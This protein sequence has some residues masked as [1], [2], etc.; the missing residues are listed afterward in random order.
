MKDTIFISHATPEDNEFTIWLASK[1]EL[2]GYK[3]WIDK[4]GLLGGEK[5]WEEI[6]NAIRNHTIKFLLVYSNNIFQKDENGNPI[7]GKLKDGVSKEYSFAENIGKKEKLKDFI[8]PLNIDSADY[9]LFIGLDRSNQI[10]FHDN[11]AQGLIQ[12]EKKL[13]KDEIVKIESNEDSNFGNWYQNEFLQYERITSKNEL[14]YTNWW[15]IQKLPDSFYMY[16]FDKKEQASVIRKQK[17]SFPISQISNYLSSF[18]H[19]IHFTYIIDETENEIKPKKIF[20]IKIADVL[21]G[22]ESNTFP[23]HRDTENHFKLLLKEVFHQIMRHRGMYWYEMA[24]KKLAYFFNTDNLPTQKVSFDYLFKDKTKTRPK[25][26]NLIGKYLEL[27]FWHYAISMKPTISP[28]FGYSLK[29]HICFTVDGKLV[30]QKEVKGNE[31]RD[32]DKEKIH[33][34]RRAKGKRMF[35]EEWR[36]LL[37]AFLSGLKKNDSIS[38]PLSESF[39]LEMPSYPMFYWADFGYYDPKDKSRQGLLNTY[40]EE[41]TEN[42]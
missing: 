26:K 31:K 6:D 15:E 3:V 2:M 42:D 11:W 17:N 20:E 8:I 35:N 29:N 1:L 33:S 13:T 10:S 38:I 30:W 16:E 23:N 7:G 9:N 22:F 40:E 36:D 21:T 24:N 18:K 12:L 34:H 28:F 19:Q 32:F 14:Y 25:K 4:N 39:I 5:F 27:G 41:E 37:L